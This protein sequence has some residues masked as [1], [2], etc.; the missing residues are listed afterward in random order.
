MDGLEDTSRPGLREGQVVDDSGSNA[1]TPLVAH[2]I[3]R[4][5]TGGLENGLVNLINRM[6]A[7]RYRHAIICLTD[8]TDFR[9][10]I[11]GADIQIYALKKREGKDPGIYVRLWRLL[12]A[13][14]PDIVHT[15]N[16][17]T[18]PCVL[19]AFLAGVPLRVH[20]EHGW[21]MLDLHGRNRKYLLLRRLCS[22]FVHRYVPLSEDLAR[23]LEQRVG[24]PRER[25]SRV[26]NGVD[27]ARFFPG[28]SEVELPGGA[29]FS[30]HGKFIVGTVGRMQPV[31]DQLTLAEA[32]VRLL[33]EQPGLRSR[34]RLVMVGD[35]PLRAEAARILDDA[36][37]GELAWLPGG[38][39]DIPA[40]LRAM[41]LFVLTSL[42]EGISNTIL[43]AMSSALP[44]IASAVGGNTELVQEDCTGILVPPSD[45]AAL[46]EAIRRYIDEPALAKRHGVNARRRAEQE[47]SMEAMVE[48]YLAVYDGLCS[49]QRHQTA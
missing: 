22:P 11:E 4:L 36:G 38:R 35:G 2:I 18:V 49:R 24:V 7:S 3:F 8:Y 10:R 12:R 33:T 43:E 23:W 44:V 42:N 15:R 5:D 45:S 20:G 28:P 41:D 34:V 1:H 6:P 29:P 21:D 9:F 40:F 46:A 26:C 16:L 37:L 17:G 30:R 25:I 31:K 19:P 47:F 27:T 39:D 13:L 48:G 14:R 32:F